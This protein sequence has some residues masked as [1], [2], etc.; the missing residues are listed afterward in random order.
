MN[1]F[2]KVNSWALGDFARYFPQ[3]NLWN[4]SHDW[5]FGAVDM[6]ITA[7]NFPSGVKLT[8]AGD[9][10]IY[11]ERGEVRHCFDDHGA[12]NSGEGAFVRWMG[13]KFPEVR[14]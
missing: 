2:S 9:G 11:A 3:G 6:S 4:H 8:F 12:G 7:Y 14:L 1:Q 13:K 5:E 10:V